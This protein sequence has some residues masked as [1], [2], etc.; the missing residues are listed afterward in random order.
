MSAP[1]PKRGSRRVRGAPWPAVAGAALALGLPGPGCGPAPEPES[2]PAEATDAELK[3]RSAAERDL[4]AGDP[5][6]AWARLE[7]WLGDPPRADRTSLLAGLALHR[8]KRYGRAQAYLEAAASAG[9]EQRDLRSG[10][11]F[12]GWCSLQLGDLDAAAAAFERH[13]AWD[14]DLGDDDLGL[15]LVAVERGQLDAARAHFEAALDAFAELER[16]GSDRK[17]ERAR[18]HAHLAEVHLSQGDDAAAL[19]ELEASVATG[20]PS[21]E[22]LHRM[23]AVRARLQANR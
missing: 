18:A 19:R 1:S 3:C 4:A 10:A 11:H 20:R 7:P 8:Q 13:R 22:V 14:P 15:G 12:L 5:T 2:A 6:S 9:E 16:K 23:N 21:A 17:R